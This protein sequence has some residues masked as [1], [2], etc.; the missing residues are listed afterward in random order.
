MNT[1]KRTWIAAAS[2][3]LAFGA[4]VPQAHALCEGCGTLLKAEDVPGD[5]KSSPAAVTS[6]KGEKM[7][8]GKQKVTVKMDDG[9]TRTLTLDEPTRFKVGDKVKIVGNGLAPQQ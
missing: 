7:A 5:A 9:K 3:A 2:V 8:G 6:S 1:N 4:W